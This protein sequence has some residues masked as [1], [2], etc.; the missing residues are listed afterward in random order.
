[1]IDHAMSGVLNTLNTPFSDRRAV[2]EGKK[3]PRHRKE[4]LSRGRR[5]SCWRAAPYMHAT[6]YMTRGTNVKIPYTGQISTVSCLE[7]AC[8]LEQPNQRHE[9]A[10]GGALEW[11]WAAE[12]L[13]RPWRSRTC[14]HGR[15]RSVRASATLRVPFAG[16][17]ICSAQIAQ[18]LSV[19][20]L[21]GF[22]M[23]TE[24]LGSGHR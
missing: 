2:I 18:K 12:P 5:S 1:M 3:F 17:P 9:A 23:S 19:A 14:H 10:G 6:I 22:H 15:C 16:F 20:R 24:E 4:G 7:P 21:E 13:G 8:W 11:S